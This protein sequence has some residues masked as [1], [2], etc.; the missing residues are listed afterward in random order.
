MP[1]TR[2]PNGVT[3]AEPNSAFD[4]FILPDETRAHFYSTDFDFYNTADWT[5]TETTT[6]ALVAQ[7]GGWLD[8]NSGDVIGNSNHQS[9]AT[10]FNLESGKQT[11][12]KA[13]IETGPANT[14]QWAMGL[15]PT[16]AT[17]P[18]TLPNQGI[19][20]QKGVSDT[21][22]A[23]HVRN[24][25]LPG[26]PAGFIDI[27]SNA[28]LDTPFTLGFHFDGIDTYRAYLDDALVGSFTSTEDVPTDL[29]KTTFAYTSTAADSLLVDYIIVAQER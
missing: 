26:S 29:L 6:S 10:L 23:F 22:I 17:G 25:G 8:T 13:Q 9:V 4:S 28:R 20:L 15:Q 11:W 18:A 16:N 5:V 7:D 19:W 2:Y 24:I 3:T 27:P 12:F 14:I 21:N 1:T